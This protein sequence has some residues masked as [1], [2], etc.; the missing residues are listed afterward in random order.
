MATRTLRLIIKSRRKLSPDPKLNLVYIY[1]ESLER[2]YFDN[3]AFPDLTPELGAL[4]NEGPDFS[5]TQQLP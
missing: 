3:E 2:T 1:G 5:H 4:K